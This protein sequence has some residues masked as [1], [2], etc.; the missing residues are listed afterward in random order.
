MLQAAFLD[1]LFLDL[2]PFSQ[3]GFVTPEVEVSGRDVFQAL[4]VALV[5]VILDEGPD[6][7]FEIAGQIVVFQQDPVLH[8]LMP[9]LDFALC[10]RVEWRAAHVGHLLFTQPFSQVARDVAGAIITEQ[11]RLVTDDGLIAARR[12]ESQFN[13]ICHV[14]GPHVNAELPGDDVTA[15]IVQNGAQIIPAVV[16]KAG[17]WRHQ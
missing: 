11:M 4:V 9:P 5:V 17:L 3:N 6:L 2:L 16:P 1:C 12:G 7:A 15:V 13:L 8:R 14:L 10:L